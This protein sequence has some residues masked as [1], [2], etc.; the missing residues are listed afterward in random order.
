MVAGMDRYYQVA[1]CFRDEDLR[2]DRQPEF[3]LTN[4]LHNFMPQYQVF[5]LAGAAQIQISVFQTQVVLRGNG[6]LNLERGCFRFGKDTQ[7]FCNQ[8]GNAR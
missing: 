8:D 2:A 1:K 3:T 4:D 6:I 7:F 5:Q